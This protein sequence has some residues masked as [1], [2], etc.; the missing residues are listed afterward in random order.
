MKK[1][2]NLC[3][4]ILLIFSLL[5]YYVTDTYKYIY[6]SEFNWQDL[7]RHVPKDA[8]HHVNKLRQI[9]IGTFGM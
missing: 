1:Y 4:I 5:H 2:N 8:L 6:Y 3:K 7:C 9:A